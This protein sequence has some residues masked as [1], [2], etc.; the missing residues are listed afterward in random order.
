MAALAGT[1]EIKGIQEALKELYLIDRKYRTQIGK[2]IKRAGDIVVKNARE[3]ISAIPPISG[4]GRGS[5]VRGRD[6]TKWSSDAA[7]KGF[8]VITNRSGRKARTV[9][10]AGGEKVDFRAQA[11]TLMVLRQRDQAAAI[12]DHAGI[13]AGSTAFVTNL[14]TAGEVK[15]GP[16]PRASEPAVEKSRA[17]V[18]VEV[19][20]I[21]KK[22]MDRVNKNLKVRYGN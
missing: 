6:G 18:E 2:D 13:K 1:M 8:I 21:V 16:P 14:N 12:W 9:T 15:A 7:K 5:L 3:L 17:G 19:T 11:Y 20:K 22:V 10:F 4:M